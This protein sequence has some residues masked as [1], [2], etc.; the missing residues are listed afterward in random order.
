MKWDL[1]FRGSVT[2]IAATARRAEE[3]GWDGIRLPE[4]AHDVFVA[5][6]LAA[7]ATT[8]LEIGTSVA[9]AFA[10]NPMTIASCAH[11]LHRV[12][13]GRFELGLG[14]QI[15]PHITKRYSMPWSSPA[16][17]M[18]ELI[19]AVR[20]I[21]ENWESGEKLNVRGSFYTHTLMTPTFS[22]GPLGFP[23]PR[24]TL[25]AVGPRM[26][27]VAAEVADGIICHPLSTPRYIES[28]VLPAL[29]QRRG[30]NGPERIELS[31]QILVATG[32]DDESLGA[33]IEEVRSRIAFYAST[34]AYRPVLEAHGLGH[35][36]DDLNALSKQG[37]WDD[38]ARRIDDD[39]LELFA[40]VA[41]PDSVRTEIERRVGY[42]FDRVALTPSG[43]TPDFLH[44]VV[45]R[46]AI[47]TAAVPT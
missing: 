8:S 19:L 21:W 15:R 22:P 34:P 26:I 41:A 30:S 27:K 4:T 23:P 18:R 43:P 6:A 37:R 20:A 44:R 31:G 25:A 14:S 10:R 5:A 2:D 32:A 3:A 40:V 47:D 35:L 45:G 7:P 42:L 24:I 13:E 38:M 33:S 1:V 28:T 29:E 16:A 9:I 17:R 12:T 39:V 11:D 46:T 36:Q